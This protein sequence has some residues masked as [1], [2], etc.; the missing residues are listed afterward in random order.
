MTS[1]L[2]VKQLNK[3]FKKRQVL[4]DVSFDC[5]MGRIVGLIGP[6]G[7]GKTTIMKSV[8]G[9]IKV[10]AQ[11]KLTVKKLVLITDQ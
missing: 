11:L 8:L 9:L 1:I 4:F 3:N 7:V 10:V 6:N 5:K 2:S